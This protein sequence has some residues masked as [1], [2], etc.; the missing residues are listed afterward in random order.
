M[1]TIR[2]KSADHRGDTGSCSTA[3]GYAKNARPGP[4]GGGK[5][6]RKVRGVVNVGNL[7][8]LA[9]CLLLFVFVL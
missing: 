8:S 9:F 6:G 7:I 5:G 2:K 3:V 1:S 4:A